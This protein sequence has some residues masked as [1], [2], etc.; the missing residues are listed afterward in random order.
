[1]H[2]ARRAGE[3]LPYQGPLDPLPALFAATR[4]SFSPKLIFRSTVYE[5]GMS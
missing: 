5:T 4:R 3:A 1:M 2:A